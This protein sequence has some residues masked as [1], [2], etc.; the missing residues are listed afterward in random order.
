MLQ[1]ILLVL[2]DGHNYTVQFPISFSKSC[3]G[4]VPV[5]EMQQAIGGDNTC[6]VWNK[7]LTSC[8]LVTDASH[9]DA[10]ADITWFAFGL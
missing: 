8:T 3:I 1:I 4:C 6:N 9:V 2:Y 7:T 10:N 5:I